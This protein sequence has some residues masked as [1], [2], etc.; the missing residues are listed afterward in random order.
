MSNANTF[1]KMMIAGGLS[2]ATAAVPALADAPC[3]PGARS[4]D[5]SANPCNPCAAAKKANPCA[6]NPCAAN[7]CAANPSKAKPCAAKPCKAKPCKP[8]A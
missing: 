4:G 7:P 2:V 3:G 1:A 6:A 8:Q 5:Y